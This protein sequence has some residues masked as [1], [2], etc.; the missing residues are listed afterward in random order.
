LKYTWALVQELLASGEALEEN[1]DEDAVNY[2]EED[3]DEIAFN[4]SNAR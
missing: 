1:E 2:K 4:G 3:L